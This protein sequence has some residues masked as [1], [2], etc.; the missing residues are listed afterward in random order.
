[1]RGIGLFR[2]EALHGYLGGSEEGCSPRY[3]LPRV[4]LFLWIMIGFSIAG[5]LMALWA[6][7]P[8]YVSGIAIFPGE[9]PVA[10]G[11]RP[12]ANALVCLE[13]P[14][15]P[16]LKKK[17]RLFLRMD[18]AARQ[19][20]GEILEVLPETLSPACI[21]K[22]FSLGPSALPGTVAEQSVVLARVVDLSGA[23]LSHTDNAGSY[24]A[25]IEVEAGHPRCILPGYAQI[26]KSFHD[27]AALHSQ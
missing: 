8:D 19:I 9:M 1:M 27:P 7:M 10:D 15:L 18:P 21:Q 23:M 12:A 17:Q 16:R 20:R 22:R 11:R 26:I 6:W 3:A 14:E 4:V 13:A 24:A 25:R 5:G 2:A